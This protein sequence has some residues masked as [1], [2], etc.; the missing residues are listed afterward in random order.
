MVYLLYIL[1]N[2]DE[3]NGKRAVKEGLFVLYL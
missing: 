1:N 2:T 3:I